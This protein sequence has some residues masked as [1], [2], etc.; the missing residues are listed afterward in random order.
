[1]DPVCNPYTPNAGATLIRPK[2]LEVSPGER[3]RGA[4]RAS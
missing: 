4:L 1:M 3:E 2:L